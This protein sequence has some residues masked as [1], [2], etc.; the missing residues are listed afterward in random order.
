VFILYFEYKNKKHILQ[1][2]LN[3]KIMTYT[4]AFGIKRDELCFCELGIKRS[5]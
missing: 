3:K 1:D 2:Y 4:G 5:V